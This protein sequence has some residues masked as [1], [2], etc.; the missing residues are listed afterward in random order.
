MAIVDKIQGALDKMTKDD[1]RVTS[2]ELTAL[3]QT[4]VVA[5]LGFIKNE[6]YIA[7]AKDPAVKEVLRN[8]GDEVLRPGMDKPRRMLE[9]ANVPFVQL[10]AENRV[11]QF[12]NLNAP[13]FNDQ[14]IVLD[15]MYWLQMGVTVAQAGAL[16]AVRGDV[17]EFVLNQRDAGMDQWRKLGMVVFRVVPNAIPPQV[18]VSGQATP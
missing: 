14:E 13:I 8:I 6:F 18:T 10:N 4:Y 11:A 12:G 17:R 15:A 7:Q 3:Q 9:K 16:A 2:A 5:Q 1:T